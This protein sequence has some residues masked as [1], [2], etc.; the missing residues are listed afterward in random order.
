MNIKPTNDLLLIRRNK[1]EEI[2]SAGGLILKPIEDN[3]DT[4]YTGVVVAAGDGKLAKLAPA[5]QEVVE[6]LQSLVDA[7]H[8]MPNIDWGARG[9]GLATWQRAIDALELNKD[10]MG[11]LPM[12]ISVGQTVVFSKHGHQVFKIN[13]EEITAISEATCLGVLEDATS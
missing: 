6:A 4:P 10:G 8:A 11:R 3:L 13:G 12:T 9:I 7:F 5:A 1:P 2:R